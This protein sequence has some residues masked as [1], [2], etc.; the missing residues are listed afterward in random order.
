MALL[1]GSVSL[2]G[3]CAYVA[4]QPWIMNGTLRDNVLLDAEF[5]AKW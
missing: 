3:A 4:Q 1:K 2:G 5:D